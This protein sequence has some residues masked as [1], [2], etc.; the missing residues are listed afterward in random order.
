MSPAQ[1]SLDNALSL[2]I[3]ASFS[4]KSEK[5]IKRIKSKIEKKENDNDSNSICD[6]NQLQRQTANL[7]V[8]ESVVIVIL[9]K[10]ASVG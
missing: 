1:I 5:K 3:F 6:S 8:V 10:S 2:G 7:A 9:M 4:R